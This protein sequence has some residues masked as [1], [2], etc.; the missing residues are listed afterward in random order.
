M[1]VTVKDYLHVRVGRPSLTAPSYQYL[2]PGSELEVDGKL[3]NGDVYK[4]VNT[5][6]KDAANNYYWSGGIDIREIVS[7]ITLQEYNEADFWWHNDFNVSELWKKGLTGDKI[8]IA[9]L[10]SGIALPHPDLIVNP[11][12]LKDLT[13]SP[14]G[15]ADQTGHGTHVAGIIIASNNGFGVKGLAYNSN[16]YLGK[17]TND[18][19]GD[20]VSFLVKSITWAIDQTVDIISISNG[21]PDNNA[22]LESAVNNA[23]AKGILV[24]AAAGNKDETTG[25]NILYPAKYSGVLSVGGVT[26]AHTPL[27]DT[28]NASD[29]NIFAPGEEILSTSLNKGYVTLTGCSQA[30]PYVAG[31]AALLLE[32]VRKK[33][34]NYR[35]H[36]LRTQLM[37]HADT[38][39]YGKLINPVNT[40]N[41][42]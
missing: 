22:A 42:L 7:A 36:D 4:G 3:Y 9:V 25:N 24:V 1:K 19:H 16:F 18:I 6:L 8:K 23:I 40:L 37:N 14:S 21:V 33:N 11:A 5:W 41:N 13:N 38:L 15:V 12:N 35:A 39:P 2:A 17:I 29:T 20:D 27:A 34:S 26:R 28:I 32:A 31:I 30:T 10:D